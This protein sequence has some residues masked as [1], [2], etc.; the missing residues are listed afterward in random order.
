MA[1]TDDA[2]VQAIRADPADDGPRLIWADWLDASDAPADRARA[3]LVR[4]QCAL[5]R[6]A[7][8]HPRRA[9]LLAAQSELLHAHEAEWSQPL[10]GLAQGCEFR[11]GVIEGATVAAATFLTHA[12]ALFAAAPLLRR[13]RVT[14]AVPH[15]GR[16]VRSPD[17]ARLHALDFCG[18]ELGT[19]GV[20]RLL[21]SPH[22]AKLHTL[23]LT[24][25][26]LDDVATALVASARTLPGLRTLGLAD[27]PRLTSVG[28]VSLSE[29]STLAEL[30]KLDLAHGGVTDAGVRALGT[31]SLAA[32]QTLTIAGNPLGDAGVAA[33]LASA[34]LPRL[35]ARRP[36]LDL[37]RCAVGPRGAA[38]LANANV[39]A[40]LV[41]LDLTGNLLGD[42]GV[43]RLAESTHLPR[44]RRLALAGNSVTDAGAVLLA[45]SPLM[46]R[47]RRLDVAGNH[48]TARGKRELARHRPADLALIDEA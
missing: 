23:D 4:T 32:L 41:E 13:V 14:D 20:R 45:R 8:H 12:D 16:L 35:L 37:S 40:P 39:L 17:L 9:E 44:L 15:L 25:N 18:N 30:R 38:S 5:A 22:L 47:L 26:R 6:L 27:N 2:F 34:L 28:A 19:A 24:A 46:A 42:L 10:E 48:L 43:M 31:S 36:A 29:S 11:R 1:T 3:D 33:L 7:S 21:T